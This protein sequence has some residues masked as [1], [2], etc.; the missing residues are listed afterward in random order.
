MRLRSC[1]VFFLFATKAL[2]H[3]VFLN[4]DD[5]PQGQRFGI[6]LLLSILSSSIFILFS[7]FYSLYSILFILFS[8]FYS[9][10]SIL[11]FYSLYSILFILF[12]LFYS[13]Y[14]IVFILFSCFLP[15]A[16]CL[17]PLASILHIKLKSTHSVSNAPKI[18]VNTY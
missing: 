13:L 1:S 17:L 9:L 11:L 2:S 18:V 3:E 16:S 14:S 6:N 5:A 4:T 15:L 10:Y 12:S 7:L 8:L